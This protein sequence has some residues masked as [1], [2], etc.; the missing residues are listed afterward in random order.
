[1]PKKLILYLLGTIIFI[2]IGLLVYWNLP[3][4]ITRKSDTLIEEN[5]ILFIRPS[6]E[7]FELLKG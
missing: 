7:K 4:E 5:Q 3:I 6:E 1:M 2:V